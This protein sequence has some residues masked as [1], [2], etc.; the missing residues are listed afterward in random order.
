MTPKQQ[1]RLRVLTARLVRA[2]G[3]SSDEVFGVNAPLR[4]CPLGAHVDHQGGSVTGLTVDRSVT[5]AAVPLPEPVLRVESL[6]FQGEVAVDLTATQPPPIGEWGDFARA[7]ADVLSTRRRLNRGVH[8]VIGGDLAG[9]GLSSSAAVLICYL[10]GLARANGFDLPRS[11]V[12]ALVQRAE[13]S[14]IGVA[15][16]LLDQSIILFAEKGHLTH[17]NVSDLSVERVTAREGTPEV[18]VVVAFS[19]ISRALTGSGFNTRVEECHEAARILLDCGGRTAG[20]RPLLSEVEPE[21]FD[22]F[23]GELPESLRR[24]AAH[25]F[26]ERQRVIDGVEV[27]RGGDLTRFG[28][29]MSASGESSIRNYECGTPELVTLYELLRNTPGVYGARFSG[30]GFGGSCVALADP[31]AGEKIANTVSRGYAEAHPDAAAN[32][33]CH[34]CAPAGPAQFVDGDD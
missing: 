9:A 16:G 17:V 11:E 33:H 12:A 20:R 28:E 3:A 5:M 22:R 29:L 25:F 6:D 1:E 18:G 24:R 31:T 10:L 4:V 21:L 2:T 34:L 7:A 8:A 27:W 19:G 26:G 23:A 30:A 15:S 14:Y 13:N 32:A